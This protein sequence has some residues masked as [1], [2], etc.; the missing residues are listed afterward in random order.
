MPHW[1]EIVL[2]VIGSGAFVQLI[3]YGINKRKQKTNEF[4][5]IVNQ[6]KSLNEEYQERIVDITKDVESLRVRLVKSER[7]ASDLQARMILYESSYMNIPIPMW[8]KDPEGIMLSVNDCYEKTY[9]IPRGFTKADY[10][11]SKDE[12]IWGPEIAKGFLKNDKH[13]ALTGEVIRTIE[14]WESPDGTKI[15]GEV[16]K[17]PRKVGD[18]VIGIAGAALKETPKDE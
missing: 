11:G 2:T 16:V 3:N 12:D 7:R 8:M 9:L 10:I 17:W 14:V 5:T 18:L 4:E 6:Y 15:E 1:V 13:V